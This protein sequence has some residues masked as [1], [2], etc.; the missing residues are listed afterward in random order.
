[1]SMLNRHVLTLFASLCATPC[2][3]ISTHDGVGPTAA[4]PDTANLCSRCGSLA[5]RTM[6]RLRFRQ[7]AIR[8]SLPAVPRTGEVIVESHQVDGH[9]TQP[10]L[11]PFSGEWPDSSPAMSPDGS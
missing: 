11:A 4:P 10:T 1:M 6:V 3:A 5:Q 8:F 2:I 9:W 7:M